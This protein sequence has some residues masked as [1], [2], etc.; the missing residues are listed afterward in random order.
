MLDA[1][2]KEAGL[3]GSVL[4]PFGQDALCSIFAS[5]P[6]IEYPHVP[7]PRTVFAGPI[8]T[9]TLAL[10]AKENPDLAQ[11]LERARTAMINLGSLFK[12]TADDA[13]AVAT[14]IADARTRLE[15]RGGLQVLWKMPGAAA[16]ASMLDAKLGP[17]DERRNWVRIEEWIDP[18]ALAVLQHP[19]LVVSVHH[20][21]ASKLC[22]HCPQR[23]ADVSNRLGA[24][25]DIVSNPSGLRDTRLTTTTTNSAGVPQIILP[26]YVLACISRRGLDQV[27]GGTTCT[28]T[29]LVLRHLGT[30]STPTKVQRPRSTPHSSRTRSCAYF[31]IARVRMGGS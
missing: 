21:G 30:A 18:P 9:P 5:I 12:Y 1:A 28:P 26:Q 27:L 22:A 15:P 31:P 24:R 16:F 19:N 13:A 25:S 17:E 4:A 8:L 3:S 7:N 20:G 29:R 6:E 23:S 11:F 14:A 2:R 10:S